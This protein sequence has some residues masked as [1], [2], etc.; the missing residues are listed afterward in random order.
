MGELKMIDIIKVI[1]YNDSNRLS[2]WMLY[3]KL[4]YTPR[5]RDT[6][7]SSFFHLNYFILSP[8]MRATYRAELMH[9]VQLLLM[10]RAF[11]YIY[12]NRLCEVGFHSHDESDTFG[13]YLSTFYN[14]SFIYP[15]KY[16]KKSHDESDT[17]GKYL[18]TFYNQHLSNQHL[19]DIVDNQFIYNQSIYSQH[20][21]MKCS[22][23]L[24]DFY[25][26]FFKK[27]L[28]I[29]QFIVYNIYICLH[30]NIC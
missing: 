27:V 25:T 11:F 23:E 17:F 10:M 21:D 7:P 22:I 13:K 26:F 30:T 8:T 9:G 5:E 14:Q 12:L 18:S 28:D 15:E 16:N 6:T 24:L 4:Q 19:G 2:S 29:I 1:D 3:S 20:I